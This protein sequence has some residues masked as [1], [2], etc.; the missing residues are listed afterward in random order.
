MMV[1]EGIV[2]EY[3]TTSSEHK[4]SRYPTC[5]R[6]E[7]VLQARR[8]QRLANEHTRHTH[9]CTTRVIETTPQL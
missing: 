3:S 6:C 9:Q 7:W 2:S 4:P 1:A 8:K 5:L